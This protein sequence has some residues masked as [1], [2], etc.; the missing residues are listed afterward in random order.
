MFKKKAVKQKMAEW[1]AVD[2]E[3]RETRNE[4]ILEKPFVELDDLLNDYINTNSK[5]RKFLRNLFKEHRN[6]RDLLFQY[7]HNK[8]KTIESVDDAGKLDL[9]L[10]AISLENFL[11]D[12]RD[13]LIGLAE[14]Y[15]ASVKAG[16]D[17]DPHYQRIGEMSEKKAYGATVKNQIGNFKKTAMFGS[18]EK[19]FERIRNQ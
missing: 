6:S 7:W 5:N 3:Y 1:D 15:L 8:T 19:K 17:P 4:S 18:I 9:C 13:S 14:L 2:N 11:F 12:D 10:A 16:I